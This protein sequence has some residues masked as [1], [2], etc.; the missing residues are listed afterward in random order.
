MGS[1]AG[2]DEEEYAVDTELDEEVNGHRCIEQHRRR[3]EIGPRPPRQEVRAD[4]SF[5]KIKFN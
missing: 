3:H 4:D 5:S 2:H 1:A